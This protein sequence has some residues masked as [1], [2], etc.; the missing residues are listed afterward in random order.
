MRGYHITS[1]RNVAAILTDGLRRDAD[2]W[3][4]AS[5][6]AIPLHDRFETWAQYD[7]LSR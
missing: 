3:V 4:T 5:T 7:A 2:G 1:E 6:G